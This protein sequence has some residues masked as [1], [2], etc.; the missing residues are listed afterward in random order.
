M[1]GTWVGG[2]VYG[3]WLVRLLSPPLTIRP[4]QPNFNFHNFF[5]FFLLS[6]F[7]YCLF[8]TPSTSNFFYNHD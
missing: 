3:L 2:G 1:G 5:I 8:L 4:L 7:W 6:I